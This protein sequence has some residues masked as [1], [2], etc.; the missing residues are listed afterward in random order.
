MACFVNET[1]GEIDALRHTRENPNRCHC[2][3]RERG[4][5]KQNYTGTCLGPSNASSRDFHYRYTVNN[6]KTHVHEIIHCSFVC[7]CK[8]LKPSWGPPSHESIWIQ[9]VHGVH[10]GAAIKNVEE[11]A[12][13]LPRR[14][15]QD[16]LSSEEMRNESAWV[17]AA[18]LLQCKKEQKIR[19]CAFMGK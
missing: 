12:C 19:K 9:D 14:D 18:S 5:S 17:P 16:M 8:V 3:E 6:G 4:H 7:H 15:F 1:V 11:E 2:G 13:D 10:S